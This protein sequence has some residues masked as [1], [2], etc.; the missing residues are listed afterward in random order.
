MNDQ[1]TPLGD[2]LAKIAR[3]VLLVAIGVIAA[4]IILGPKNH[5]LPNPVS[6]GP[7]QADGGICAAPGYI[8]MPINTGGAA[9]FY[10]CDTNKQVIC[11]YETKGDHLRLVG[12][13][14]FD[15]DL[16]INDGAIPVNG[17]ILDGHHPGLDRAEAAAYGEGIKAA[18]E[19]AKK[20]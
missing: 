8:M 3:F 19:K 13:R 5:G 6:V 4:L 18:R 14:K 16:E 7:V 2:R 17:K 12:V 10:V 20:P 15:K 9:K 11:V 1:T